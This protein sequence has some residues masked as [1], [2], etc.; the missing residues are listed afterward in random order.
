MLAAWWNPVDW[1]RSA[2]GAVFGIVGDAADDL[3]SDVFNWIS[4]LLV[5][6]LVWLFNVVYDY[7][8]TTTTPN[9]YEA[10]F[11]DGPFAVAKQLGFVLLFLLT[12]LAV[13]ETVWNRDGG[14]LFRSLGQDAPKVLFLSLGLLYIT[15][16]SLVAADEISSLLM[17]NFGDDVV[18][19]T[20]RVTE[21][22]DSL[23]FG[24]GVLVVALV[25]LFLTLVTCFVVLELVFREA[26][27]LILVALV[28]VL[29][30]TEVYRPTKGMG[31]RAG[32]LLIVTVA[33]KPLIALCLAVGAAAMGQQAANTSLDAV[34][35]PGSQPRRITQE[36]F[37]TWATEARRSWGDPPYGYSISA[38]QL[39]AYLVPERCCGDIVIAGSGPRHLDMNAPTIPT[40]VVSDDSI[41]DA[42]TAAVGPMFALMMAGFAAMMLAAFSPFL[43]M[44]LI[45]LDSGADTGAARSA[46][47]GSLSHAKNDTVRVGAAI[48]KATGK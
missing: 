21:I 19:F 31:A 7:V 34:A 39:D 42:D 40:E 41:D 47:G 11:A 29:L 9:L 23:S 6:G 48:T 24:A 4:G 25:A 18:A 32:R 15:T 43:L 46:V 33:A 37:D 16:L 8:S 14:Q 36:E 22:T 17:A 20:D 2:A 12:I 44:R 38:E 28:A 27:V 5:R 10:W 35:E 45:S 1:I 13:A 3:L 26:F 30:A